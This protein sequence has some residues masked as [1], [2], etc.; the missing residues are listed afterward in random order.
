MQAL[1]LQFNVVASSNAARDGYILAAVAERWRHVGGRVP[2][3]PFHSVAH[4]RRK[5]ETVPGTPATSANDAIARRERRVFRESPAGTIHR[6]SPCGIPPA[7]PRERRA[8]RARREFPWEPRDAPSHYLGTENGRR[9]GRLGS[10]RARAPSS[11]R[12]FSRAESSPLAFSGHA[13][14]AD[15]LRGGD[16]RTSDDSA[17]WS[18]RHV[19]SR[20][21]F[22]LPDA[23]DSS[24]RN[25]TRPRTLEPRQAERAFPAPTTDAI[26]TVSLATC[27]RRTILRL[28]SARPAVRAV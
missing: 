14:R 5:R 7:A 17:T 15:D 9:V 24:R 26:R 16:E 2:P 25:S 19:A 27:S 21:I 4:A 12:I 11:S 13:C 20:C 28:G 18:R 3:A 1:R 23:T 22:F 10:P 6:G 8:R